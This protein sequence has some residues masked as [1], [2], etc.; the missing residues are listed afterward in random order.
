MSEQDIKDILFEAGYSINEIEEI[1]AANADKD[2]VEDSLNSS[3]SVNSMNSDVSESADVNA[4]DALKEIRVKNVGKIVIWTLNINSLAPKFDQL[5]EII[6]KNLD[7]L[8][9]QETK[10]DS[11]FPSQQLALAGF[12]EPYR[13]DRNREGGGVLVVVKE[14][15][16]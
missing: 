5:S 6:G 13:L 15:S 7:I 3:I 8:T 16:V 10:L 1:V 9:I 2:G 14:Y 12:S 4:F 11:S